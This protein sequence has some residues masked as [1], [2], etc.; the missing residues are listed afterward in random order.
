MIDDIVERLRERLKLAYISD[1]KCG[2]CQHVPAPD[3]A[4]AATEIETLRAELVESQLSHAAARR[5]FHTM[6]LAAETLRKRVGEVEGA[7]RPFNRLGALVLAEAPP[8]A[9]TVLVFTSATGE[10][11]SMR[12]DHFREVRAALNQEESKH[13]DL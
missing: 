1:C 3:I 12:L 7:L 9:E 10:R 6:Q 13:A 5:N 11:Y 8:D 2:E 4:E